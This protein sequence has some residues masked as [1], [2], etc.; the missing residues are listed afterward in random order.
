M[1]MQRNE[2]TKQKLKVTKVQSE[3]GVQGNVNK[4]PKNMEHEDT[5]R[6][7]VVWLQLVD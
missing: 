7:F 6:V 1:K 2:Q 5:R 3:S 4:N